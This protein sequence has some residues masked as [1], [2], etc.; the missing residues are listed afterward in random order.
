M[1]ESLTALQKIRDESAGPRITFLLRDPDQR[2]QIAAVEA[3]GL[4]RTREA[5]P[6][7]LEALKRARDAKVRRAILEFS[8][9]RPV[10]IHSFGPVLGAEAARVQQWLEQAQAAGRR[11]AARRL[12]ASV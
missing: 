6:D 5:T 4:L 2:V 8:G 9:I 7:L 11:A 3:V 12:K 10:R 1:Y